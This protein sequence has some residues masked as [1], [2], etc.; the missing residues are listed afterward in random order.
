MNKDEFREKFR[1]DVKPV[2]RRFR[3]WVAVAPTAFWLIVVLAVV[4]AVT[5]VWWML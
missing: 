4:G 1:D 2:L 5:V 3:E